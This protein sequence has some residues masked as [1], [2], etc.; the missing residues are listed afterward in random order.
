[1]NRI[2]VSAI[3]LLTAGCALSAQQ[4]SRHA[5]ELTTG[6]TSLAAGFDFPSHDEADPGSSVKEFYQPVL[7]L[8][9]TFS[10]RKRWELSLLASATMTVYDRSYYPNTEEEKGNKVYDYGSGPDR[11]VRNYSVVPA[12]SADF[13]YKWLLRTNVEMYSSLG[14]GVSFVFPVPYLYIAPVGIKAGG[15][16][17]YAIAELN[18]SPHTTFGMA[19]IGVRI[20]NGKESQARWRRS[21]AVIR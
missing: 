20:G 5:L 1:M 16:R 14:I 17:V 15:R 7:A 3:I 11:V 10:Y 2:L 8:G 21:Q 4:S 6:Y 9:W 13:R 18:C 19:G 12:V